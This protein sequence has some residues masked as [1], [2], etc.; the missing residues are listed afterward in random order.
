MKNFIISLATFALVSNTMAQRIPFN[1]SN[2]IQNSGGQQQQS[3]Q[4][5]SGQQQSGSVSTLT[6]TTINNGYSQG[7]QVQVGGTSVRL[8]LRLMPQQRQQITTH[9]QYRLNL[10]LGRHGFIQTNNNGG[11]T[12][13]GTTTGGTT[14]GTTTGGTTGGTTTGGTTGGGTTGGGTTGGGTTGGG[15]T[16]GGSGIPS[17]AVGMQSANPER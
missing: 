12:T 11:T 3:G 8:N 4:Q 16:G 15:T 9:R 10:R 14:G 7:S 2:Q 17:G 13:G 5:Q 6:A 1:G